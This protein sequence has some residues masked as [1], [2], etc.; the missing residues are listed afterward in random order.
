MG[1]NMVRRSSRRSEPLSAPWRALHAMKSSPLQTDLAGDPVGQ[2]G[3]LG[4]AAFDHRI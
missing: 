2:Y 4:G 1:R 3:D